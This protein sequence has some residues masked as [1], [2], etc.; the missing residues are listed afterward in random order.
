MTRTWV[1]RRRRPTATVCCETSVQCST[2]SV[3]L[4]RLINAR[5]V[6][7]SPCR[8]WRAASSHL[9]HHYLMP[10]ATLENVVFRLVPIACTAPTITIEINPA[11][12]AYSIAVAPDSLLQNRLTTCAMLNPDFIRRAEASGNIF[13]PSYAALKKNERFYLD[14]PPTVIFDP[15]T[16]LQWS[17]AR[18]GR[19]RSWINLIGH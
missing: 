10:L 6:T 1:I 17:S 15:G 19:E 11:I 2:G 13:S 9:V 16:T 5:S 3:Q 12:R 18:G 14:C 7:R 4:S 8:R